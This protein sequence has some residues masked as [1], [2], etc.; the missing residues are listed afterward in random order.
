MIQEICNRAADVSLDDIRCFYLL[1][2]PGDDVVC[3]DSYALKYVH[4]W[5]VTHKML[6]AP[7]KGE[8]L[9]IMFILIFLSILGNSASVVDAQQIFKSTLNAMT[10]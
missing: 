3:E 8:D 4:D 1:Q 9:D 2:N 10:N 7:H 5:F 6:E